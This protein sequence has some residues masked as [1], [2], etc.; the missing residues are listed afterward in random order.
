MK[1]FEGK[2]LF[3]HLSVTVDGRPLPEHLEIAEFTKS[4][5]EWTYEGD[6]PRQLAL[7]I[8]YEHLGDKT[9]AIGLADRFMKKVI[10]DLDNDWTL[11]GAAIDAALAD[12]ERA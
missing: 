12:I 10:A 7:A 3:D 6:S 9:R 11:T 2:R 5:F 4:G 1:T 8:L